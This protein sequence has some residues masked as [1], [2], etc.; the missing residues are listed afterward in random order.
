MLLRTVGYSGSES[1]T[2]SGDVLEDF[3]TFYISEV[4]AGIWGAAGTVLSLLCRERK[5]HVEEN[6]VVR[7]DEA[8]HTKRFGDFFKYKYT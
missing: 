2:F 5:I 3:D 1:V 8:C 7:R 4:S 6:V